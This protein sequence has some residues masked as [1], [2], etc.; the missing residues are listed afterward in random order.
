[1]INKKQKTK[2]LLKCIC[3][4]LGEDLDKLNAE[5]LKELIDS[6]EKCKNF[7]KSLNMTVECYQKYNVEV[8]EDMHERLIDYLGLKEKD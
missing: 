1:M 4:N 3:G 6:N 8:N 2:D 5:E 7:L